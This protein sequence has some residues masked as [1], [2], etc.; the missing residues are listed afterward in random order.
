MKSLSLFFRH[1][2]KIYFSVEKL[3]HTIASELKLKSDSDYK[4]TEHDLPFTS[5]LSTIGKNISFVRKVQ[6]EIN[7]ITGD[8]HYA[9]LGCDRKNVNILTIHDCVLLH[10]Y[11]RFNPRHWVIRWLW[12]EL[13]VRKADVVTVISESTKDDLMKFTSCRTEKIRV[14]PNFADPLYKPVPGV[15][16]AQCPKLLFIGTASNKNLK[17][18]A[19]AIRG[20]NVELVIIGFPD[21]L[22]IA[23]LDNNHIKYRLL[24]NLSDQQMRDM[25]AA[26]DILLFPSTYEGFGLPIIEAQSVGRPVITSRIEP[27]ASVAGDAAVL[28]DPFE[29]GSIRAAIIKLLED[30][31]LRDELVNKGFRNAGRFRLENVAAQY[32]SLYRD[33]LRKK[34][35]HVRHFGN[36]K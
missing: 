34:I 14:I 9:I 3:F 4:V 6:S 10:Q 28:I 35:T 2:H 20:L 15:F 27:M 17:R 36:I 33:M 11:S 16:S 32:N 26:S 30:G 1:P 29:V 19:E 22:Q 5:K 7:H 13:P 23:D 12:Y 31:A 8:V 25:Y 18:T 21:E 24:N